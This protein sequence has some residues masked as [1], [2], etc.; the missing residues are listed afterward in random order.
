[1][2]YCGKPSRG[3][4]NCSP[5]ALPCD[6]KQPA[7]SRCV[8]TKK[9]CPGYRDQ[10]VLLFRDETA[11]TQVK[12]RRGHLRSR[13]PGYT[14]AANA[15][16]SPL[17]AGVSKWSHGASVSPFERL[18]PSLDELVLCR[19]YHTTLDNLSHADPVRFLHSQ[20]PDLYAR[21]GPNS[22]LRLATEAISYAASRTLAHEAALVSRIRYVQAIKAVGKAIRDPE[23]LE[24]DQTLYATL[25]L[26]GYET[27]L[28]DPNTPSAWGAHVDGAAALVKFRNAK[29]VHTSLSR[30]MFRFIRRNVVLG[31]MQMCRPVDEVFSDTD[32]PLSPTQ[33][34]EDYLV[35][36]AAQISHIQYRSNC[37][38]A[39]RQ[40]PGKTD[41]EDLFRSASVLDRELSE[42]S[43][44]LPA[45]WS[46]LAAMNIDSLGG[47]RFVPLQ[48]HRYTDLYTARVWNFY[49][50]SRLIVQ[51]VIIRT[52]SWLS[53]AT[54][55]GPFMDVGRIESSSRELVND[56][57]ATVPFLLGHDLSKMKL[58]ISERGGRQGTRADQPT[59]K[60][61]SLTS[62]GGFSLI[63]TLFVAC[64]CSPVPEAQR[65]W[66]LAQLRCLSELWET[67][68]RFACSEKSELL[69]GGADSVR[70]D[71][72]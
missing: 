24:H 64:S 25:L 69:L 23:E 6:E 58:P 55:P 54:E 71:C 18:S 46:Y 4:E 39:Q 7:C 8:R 37:L 62:T 20:L 35:W 9:T 57:C 51:S 38:F 53:A 45:T 16:Q 22:A 33:C 32:V 66:M 34:P 30:S 3:C 12:I 21:S 59:T 48:V 27:M 26:S 70:F 68:A 17:L 28:G 31:Q 29:G 15:Q 63:W 43:C 65:E 72:V 60:R 14:L 50:V 5:P 42:W 52:A 1:M 19:F 49:R 40:D 41:V 44:T 67:Q 13:P 61:N 10:S 2:V 56:I 47:S 11:R 36:K